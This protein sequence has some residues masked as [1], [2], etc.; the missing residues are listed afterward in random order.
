MTTYTDNQKNNQEGKVVAGINIRQLM[1]RARRF[2]YVFA[3]LPLALLGLAWL[4][5]QYQVPIFEVKSTL[6]FKDDNNKQGVSANDIIAKE[7]ELGGGKKILA[8]ESKIM[9]S[10]NVIEQVVQDLKLDRQVFRKGRFRY[11]E[12]YGAASPVLIDSFVLTDTIKGFKAPLSIESEKTYILTLPDQEQQAGTFGTVL[13]NKFGSFLIRKNPN[14]QS[15]AD[16]EMLI[17]CNGTEKTARSIIGSIDIVLP[18]KESN[19]VEPTM[20]TPQP[21][22]AKDILQAMVNVYNLKNVGDKQELSE[23]TLTFLGKRLEALNTELSGVEQNVE[24]Y[25]TREGMTAEAQTDINYFFNKLGEYDSELVKLEVQNSLLASI[26]SLL[27]KQ[28]FNFDLLPT[29][30]ELKS[31]S[32]QSQIDNYNKTVLERNRLAKVAGDANP[33]LK[34]LTGEINTIKG[35]IIGSIRR[36]KQEN[37]ALLAQ[38]QNKNRQF[39]NKLSKTPRNERELT[40]IKRQQNIKEGLYLF[41]L[42]K[43]EETT[44]SLAGVISDAR[45]VDRPIISEQPIGLKK[46]YLYI[47]ALAA[48]VFLSFVFVVLQGLFVNT[49]QS[50]NDIVT[51]TTM[52]ILGKIPHNKT[53]NNWVMS[54]NSNTLISEMFR[55]LRIN[56]QVALSC[57]SNDFGVNTKPQGQV[58]LITSLT[59]GEGKDFISLNLGMSSAMA[60]QKTVIVNLDLRKPNLAD[61]FPYLNKNIGITSYILTPD[62]YP[63]EVIQQSGLHKSLFYI[64]SGNLCYNPAESLSDSKIKTL[65]TYLKDNFEYIIVN[66]PPVGL[67]SDALVIKSFVDMT[68]FVVRA[69]FTPKNELGTLNQYVNGLKLPNPVI[70]FNDL[71]IKSKKRHPY[72]SD[73]QKRQGVFS[74][75]KTPQR[76]IKKALPNS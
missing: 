21:D 15:A 20:K 50:E 60:N 48:G 44:I 53:A 18:K 52:P 3:V 63:P 29:N 5:T 30:L 2:W 45:I 8:D 54:G 57:Q 68:L 19:I 37:A 40:D 27:T 65:F 17:A 26:E 1:Q 70:I 43:Q 23:N 38:N 4:Y 74:E 46:S 11:E 12:I 14:S 10:Y 16:K 49:V 36:V 41:L 55:S 25:K 71:K 7:L 39:T 13:T 22:K 61:N 47:L 42:Q 9:T 56:L 62:L 76:W 35:A 64:H 32:L 72:F 58:L 31:T 66:T 67:V 73:T 59:N 34:N 6:I 69:G 24:A 51:Q 33:T 28:D 75:K